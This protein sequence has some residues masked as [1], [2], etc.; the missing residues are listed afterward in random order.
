MKKIIIILLIVAGGVGLGYLGWRLFFAPEPIALPEGIGELPEAE[1]APFEREEPSVIIEAR[2]KLA[3]ISSV[4]I[5]DYWVNKNTGEFYYITTNGEIYKN[6]PDGGEERVTAQTL[7]NFH[8]AKPS[9]DGLKALLTVGYP[10]GTAVTIFDTVNSTFQPLP[11]G[12]ISADWDPRSNDRIA[13]IRINGN[14][15]RSIINLLTLSNGREIE[16]LRFNQTD[17]ELEWPRPGVLY[18]I[19]KPSFE[20]NSSIW[21]LNITNKNIF[22]V[23]KEEAG[24]DILWAPEGNFGLKFTSD[25]FDHSFDIIDSRNRLLAS[26]DAITLSSKCAFGLINIYC[27]IPI[28]V[29]PRIKLPDDYFKRKILFDDLIYSIDFSSGN[30]QLLDNA[31]NALIA[32]DLSLDAEHLEF[33]DNKLTFIN[34]YDQKLYSLSLE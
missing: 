34:R 14:N 1:P 17:L 6:S 8:K 19:Q 26:L 30:V 4:P 28:T 7:N 5:A 12:T 13:Y 32:L 22:P 11:A 27:A 3:T 10:F 33:M 2:Q 9:P 18:L 24:L 20:Y 21:E 29:P 15:G 31:T 16:V 23:I 25:G